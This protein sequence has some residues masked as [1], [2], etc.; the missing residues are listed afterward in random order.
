MWPPPN[1]I[2]PKQ[3]ESDIIHKG[4]RR[5]KVKLK[6]KNTLPQNLSGLLKSL[7]DYRVNFWGDYRMVIAKAITAFESNITQYLKLGS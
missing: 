5:Q 1:L 7:N 3:S 4:K 2:C 6:F